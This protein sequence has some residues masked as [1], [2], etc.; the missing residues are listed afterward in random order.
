M[1]N[2]DAAKGAYQ[3][4]STGDLETLK[5]GFTD[6]AQWQTS[7]ELQLGGVRRRDAIMENFAQIGNTGRASASSRLSS[8]M[9]A[10]T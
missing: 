6:D 3:G 1:G 7:D 9:P 4:F 5:E 2:A 8:S 10:T